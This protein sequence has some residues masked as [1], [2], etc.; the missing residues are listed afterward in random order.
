MSLFY[1]EGFKNVM[2]LS[3]N[4]VLTVPQ[5]SLLN[6]GLNFIPTRGSNKDIKPQSRLDIQN[7]HRRL[8]LW[9]Y[10]DNQE[11]SNKL[12]FMP[13]SNWTPADLSVPNHICELIKTDLDYFQSHFN[14]I[15]TTSNL[16]LEENRAL[17]E[18]QLNK[19]IVIKPADKDS[20]VVVMDLEQYL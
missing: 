17:Q 10:Y 16:S 8:K 1:Q 2:V 14:I 12:P 19:N 6:R 13:Q 20:M 11:M 7:Y 4:T 18:L 9:A 5:L 15:K 3:K